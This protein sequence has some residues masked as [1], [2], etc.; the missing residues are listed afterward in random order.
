MVV[1]TQLA[2][3]S[4]EAA[5]ISLED[6]VAEISPPIAVM[7][8]GAVMPTKTAEMKSKTMLG[9][10]TRNGPESLEAVSAGTARVH[11]T[12]IEERGTTATVEEGECGTG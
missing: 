4:I 11:I 7:S 2:R 3:T 10:D 5:D 8:V 12:T 1:L 6:I 9:R